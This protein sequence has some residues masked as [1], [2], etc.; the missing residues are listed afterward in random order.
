MA[1][2]PIVSLGMVDATDFDNSTP[3]EACVPKTAKTISYLLLIALIFG[4]VSGWLGGLCATPM[5][6][7]M[8]C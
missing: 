6:S 5:T 3:R 1:L 7:P 4:V 8:N 2:A